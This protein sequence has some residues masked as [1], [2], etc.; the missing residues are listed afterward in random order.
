[1]NYNVA[2][3]PEDNNSNLILPIGAIMI[4]TTAIAP[5]DFLLCNGSILPIVAYTPLYNVIGN[6]FSTGQVVP[7]L[8]NLTNYSGAISGNLGF[9][10]PTGTNTTLAENDTFIVSGTTTSIGSSIN[11]VTFTVS[12]VSAT[13][14]ITTFICAATYNGSGG[15]VIRTS[16]T[17]P[18]TNGKTV[19][20]VNST[21]TLGSS[22]GTDSTT[23]VATNLPQHIHG[24]SIGTTAAMVTG[25]GGSVNLTGNT[26]TSFKTTASQTYDNTGASFTQLPMATVNSYIGINYIIKYV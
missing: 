14:I 1:M 7:S 18:N 9:I 17:L 4:W 23:I 20:G 22:A 6:L 13:T 10:I 5:S 11:G 24:Y 12:S 26:M 19:R 21:Y 3:N 16:F 2:P 15:T 25:A 8:I